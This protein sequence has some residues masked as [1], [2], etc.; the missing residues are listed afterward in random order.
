[1]SS[2]ASHITGIYVSNDCTKKGRKP[3][4]HDV[5]IHYSNGVR[6][7]EVWDAKRIVRVL[8]KEQLQK[9]NQYQHFEYADPHRDTSGSVERDKHG[10][11]VLRKARS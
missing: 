10:R 7:L 5:R 6:C 9:T 11:V 2:S 1:M 8:P 3:C 4:E